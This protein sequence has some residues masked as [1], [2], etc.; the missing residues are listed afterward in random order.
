MG[1]PQIRPWR[2]PAALRAAALT[3]G[4]VLTGVAGPTDVA[5]FNILAQAH[6]Q[7]PE[8]AQAATTSL[9]LRRLDDALFVVRGA[10]SNIVI[11]IADDGLL[12]VDGGPAENVDLLLEVISS[13][14]PDHHITTLI[15]THWHPR[16]TGLN[17]RLGADG[18]T[19]IAHENTRLWL[20]TRIDRPW[21]GSVHPPLPE[22]ARPAVTFYRSHDM[23]VGDHPV[24]LG[25]LLQ[26]HTDGDIYVH[27]PDANV[28]AVGG[29]LSGDG[30]PLIDWWTGGWFGGLIDALDRLIDLAD[31]DTRIVPGQGPLLTRADLIDQRAMFETLYDR[32][33]DLFVTAHDANEAVAAR[34]AA[35]FEER[36]GDA[37]RFI[38]LAFES[39]GLYLTPDV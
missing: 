18:A 5:G 27:F 29:V 12:L 36:L 28:I 6:A 10:G 26:A 35:E 9:E 2:M 14:W 16:S 34:P 31:D 21:D 32:L 15:N 37:E 38:R 33:L 23:T 3:A 30:W 19:I 4:Y 39:I 25:Y 8:Q 1:N 22:S 24:Q 11:A 7:A 17:Q 20:G 13:E